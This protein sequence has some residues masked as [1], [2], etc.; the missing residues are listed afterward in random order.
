MKVRR[1]W[2]GGACGILLGMCTP[3]RIP[4]S[5]ARYGSCQVDYPAQTTCGLCRLELEI[6]R[7][8]FELRNAVFVT[9]FFSCKPLHR[10]TQTWLQ[11]GN[12]G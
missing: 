2:A 6:D 5:E 8:R 3:Q 12:C 11:R 7:R 1:L 4:T 10:G 9:F